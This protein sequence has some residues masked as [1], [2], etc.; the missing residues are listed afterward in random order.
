MRVLPD[1][2]CLDADSALLNSV[3]ESP[4]L[5]PGEQTLPARMLRRQ[6]GMPVATCFGSFGIFGMFGFLGRFGFLGILGRI[7][8]SPAFAQGTIGPEGVWKA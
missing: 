5:S 4:G 6:T 1:P 8:L 2:A 3:V 7:L